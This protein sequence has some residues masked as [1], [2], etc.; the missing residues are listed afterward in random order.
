MGRCAGL[1]WSDK[2]TVGSKL[3]LWAESGV[4]EERE[5]MKAIES[6]LKVALE[7]IHIDG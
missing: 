7:I 4:E 2:E 1:G 6:K 5:D 3:S